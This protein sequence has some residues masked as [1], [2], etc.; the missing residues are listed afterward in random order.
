MSSS[1]GRHLTTFHLDG[2]P[3]VGLQIVQFSEH[4]SEGEVPVT[5]FSDT[6]VSKSGYPANL[7]ISG[8]CEK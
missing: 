4:P 6:L 8:F 7:P 1:S 3:S 5:F 2:N